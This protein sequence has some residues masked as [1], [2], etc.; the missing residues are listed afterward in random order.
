M[1][2]DDKVDS[3]LSQQIKD[4]CG[5]IQTAWFS[6]LTFLGFFA[7]VILSTT[8]TDF[9][10]G[11]KLTQIP[12]INTAVPAE[13]FFVVAPVLALVLYGYLHILCMKLW[14][15]ARHA[16]KETL[17]D[18]MRASL[19]AD[20]ALYLKSR[21]LSRGGERWVELIMIATGFLLWASQ[22][23]LLWF[24][25]ARGRA[26]P[27]QVFEVDLGPLALAFADPRTVEGATLLCL[28]ISAAVGLASLLSALSIRSRAPGRPRGALASTAIAAAFVLPLMLAGNTTPRPAPAFLVDRQDL[29]GV[30]KDWHRASER[31]E[32]FRADW[33]EREGY[34]KAICGP[35]PRTTAEVRELANARR[36][37][38]RE[39]RNTRTREVCAQ[40]FR[41]LDAAFDADWRSQ[42]EAELARL[43]EL[44]LDRR[45]LRNA[46]AMG[47]KFISARMEGAELEGA[48]LSAAD[49]EGA[50]LKGANLESASA[51]F[52]DFSRTDLTGAKLRHANLTSTGFEHAILREADLSTALLIDAGLLSANLRDADLTAA[53]L[54]DARFGRSDL[55]H[56]TLEGAILDGADLS[57][58]IGLVQAQLATAVGDDRT[59]LPQTP[60]GFTRLTIASCWRTFPEPVVAALANL[61]PD[62]AVVKRFADRRCGRTE[63]PVRLPEA[64]FRAPPQ[65]PS[66]D[67]V[68]YRAAY[69]RDRLGERAQ[70]FPAAE[71]TAPPAP[72]PP[73]AGIPP[74]EARFAAAPPRPRPG[75]TAV[76][77]STRSPSKP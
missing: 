19:I 67:I 46:S 15:M 35:L 30:G 58:T 38:C 24:A 27:K 12:L 3:R 45:D 34:A 62:D 51:Y 65:T 48:I 70:V 54:T 64:R 72:E 13:R 26:A 43:P 9:V 50:A 23:L 52:A 6:L 31:R 74:D 49:F 47:T 71:T 76:I 77:A 63:R 60:S 53:D 8:D 40:I 7:V 73:R 55:S 1:P 44:D 61:P 66:P 17:A 41:R 36:A 68:T 21:T 69:E 37:Y 39:T 10:A 4:L 2:E 57:E 5:L 33:C 20:I 75:R 56:A 16:G 28:A 11:T 32:A 14:S 18:G 29:V 42:R 25:L 22:P 59:L